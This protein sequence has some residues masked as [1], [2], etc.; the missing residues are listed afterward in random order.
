MNGS[1][2]EAVTKQNTQLC[3]VGKILVSQHSRPVR[4]ENGTRK[5]GPRSPIVT[6]PAQLVRFPLGTSMSNITNLCK[7][8][9]GDDIF[10]IALYLHNN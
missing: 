8:I 4:S 10:L 9:C 5:L 7:L 2:L 3:K 6:V 1:R